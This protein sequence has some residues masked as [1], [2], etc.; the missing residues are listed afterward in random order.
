[1]VEYNEDV[2]DWDVSDDECV[3]EFCDDGIQLLSTCHEESPEEPVNTTYLRIKMGMLGW[4]T[5]RKGM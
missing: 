3:P 1:M 5:V 4:D 2:L